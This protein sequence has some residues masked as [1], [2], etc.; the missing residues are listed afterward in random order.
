MLDSILLNHATMKDFCDY[1]ASKFLYR[2]GFEWPLLLSLGI[3][4]YIGQVYMTKAFQGAQTNIVAPLKYL[5]V[6]F[7]MLLGIVWFEDL[8]NFW[9]LVGILLVITGLI[10]NMRI[11]N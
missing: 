8:Y 4:G 10:L 3:F 7:T 2:E 6:V 1:F 11:K 9:S 5:E